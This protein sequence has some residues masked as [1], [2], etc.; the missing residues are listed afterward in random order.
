MSSAEDDPA[1][2]PWHVKNSRKRKKVERADW[3]TRCKAWVADLAER[4]PDRTMRH[5]YPCP[6]CKFGF[7]VR[8][9]NYSYSPYTDV[10]NSCTCCNPDCR[11]EWEEVS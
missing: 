2:T 7:V 8:T 6:E 9:S 4:H 10:L 3:S 11:H 5:E 1:S